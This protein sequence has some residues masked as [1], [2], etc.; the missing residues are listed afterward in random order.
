M[1]VFDKKEVIITKD[2]LIKVT[3]DICENDI[4]E[5]QY[6]Y[7]VTTGHR[8]WG[9]DSVESIEQFDICSDNCLQKK[10]DLFLKSD[11]FTKY[12]NIEKTR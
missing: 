5:G 2:V 10:F 1:K 6:R 7:K 12:I 3:C 11:E 4:P 8:D 9:Y